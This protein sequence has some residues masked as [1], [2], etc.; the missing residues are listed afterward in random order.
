MRKYSPGDVVM[1]HPDIANKS[2][3]PNVLPGLMPQMRE[4]A[5]VIDEIH[6]DIPEDGIIY[7]L[8][9]HQCWWRY[10]W[11]VPLEDFKNEDES[12]QINDASGI[13]D[14]I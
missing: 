1:I 14:L 7:K 10:D 3:F 6:Q 4:L 12:N 8:K 2:R 11:L 13:E 5:G 9:N